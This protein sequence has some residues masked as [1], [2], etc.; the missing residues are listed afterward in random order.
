MITLEQIQKLDGKVKKAVEII[1]Q[2]KRE[3]GALRGKLGEYEKR[4]SELEILIARFKDDQREI[5]EKILHALSQLDHIEYE[6]AEREKT[7]PE[8]K[9]EETTQKP[10]EKEENTPTLEE[11]ATETVN[12]SDIP[13][14][15]KP[16]G[17]DSVEL[18]IF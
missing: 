14:E 16:K 5:E 6:I 18:D 8:K 1:D 10:P 13:D 9:P 4:I 7:S 3:N 12:D 15:E 17:K 11:T 2:L